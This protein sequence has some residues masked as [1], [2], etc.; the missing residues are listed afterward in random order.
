[1]ADFNPLRVYLSFLGSMF[2][3]TPDPY[4]LLLPVDSALR[5]C[6]DRVDSLSDEGDV[7]WAEQVAEDEAETV[8]RLVGIAFTICQVYIT[9]IVSRVM[10]LHEFA[11]RFR[12]KLRTT[13]GTKSGIVRSCS[14]Q[15]AGSLISQVQL[16]DQGANYAKHRE[17]WRGTEWLALSGRSR[18][19]AD[20]LLAVGATQ[21]YTGN[22][23]LILEK[24]VGD[25]DL[26]PAR[27]VPIL[28]RWCSDLG[29]QYSAEL[30]RHIN[31]LPQSEPPQ[32]G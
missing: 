15:V 2:M 9:G 26:R 18:K 8:E 13:D 30:R 19:T 23:S 29:S 10:R 31:G 3:L 28:E 27:L 20:A 7:E 32:A 17:E 21:G 24:L 14:K 25:A 22:C 6:S 16:I 11:G 5:E 4:R 12:V 1:M